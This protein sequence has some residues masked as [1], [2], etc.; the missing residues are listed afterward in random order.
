MMLVHDHGQTL[1][2]SELGRSFGPA[3]TTVRRYLDILSGTFIL[4]QLQPWLENIAKRQV[5][6]PKLYVRDCGLLHT[7][8]GIQDRDALLRHPKLGPS[9]EGLA[10]ETIIR[11]HGAEP[12]DC[13]FWATHG[14]AELDLLILAEGRRLGYEVKYTDQPRIT[15]SLRTACDDLRLDA[16]RVVYPG[17]CRFRLTKDIEAVGLDALWSDVGAPGK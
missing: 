8:L 1:N 13:Y 4:R 6:A 17:Q 14:A 12:D 2:F 7:L 3:D 10:I 16:L 5:K 11:S 15:R 9:W